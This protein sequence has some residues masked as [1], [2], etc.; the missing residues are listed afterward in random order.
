MIKLVKFQGEYIDKSIQ[1]HKNK[2]IAD[3]IGLW[4]EYTD[5][6]LNN[7]VCDWMFGSNIKIFGI[8]RD[9]KP[10]G[11]IM[12]KNIDNQNRTADIHITIGEPSLWGKMSSYIA[13]KKML[14]YGFTELNLN[15]IHTYCLETCP[16]LVKIM[17]KNPFG[18]KNEGFLRACLNKNNKYIG[19]HIYGL[20]KN[21]FYKGATLC[22]Q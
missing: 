22:P 8:E 6:N 10:I 14:V 16:T 5:E 12:F 3:S 13:Y 2:K 18:F 11:Y 19:T 9:S 17:N 1:W 20:L 15:K 4:G 21:D 7:L